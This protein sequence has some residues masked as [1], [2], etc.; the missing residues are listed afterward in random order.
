[1]TDPTTWQYMAVAELG[2]RPH[3]VVDGAARPG[4]VCTL[5]HWP[6]T[7]T[8][9][10]LWAD[11]SAEIV[12]R[13]LRRPRLLPADV[14]L[15]TVDHYDAD[16][17][18]ALA[19][20]VVEGLAERHGPLLAA[21][22]RAGDFGVVQSRHS[23]LVA[24]ALAALGSAER[25]LETLPGLAE[26]PQGFED[27]WGREAAAYD[28]A[29]AWRDSGAIDIEEDRARDLVIARID[30]DV[31]AKTAVGWAGSVVH[32]AALHSVTTCLRVA[33]VVGRR[34]QLHYRYESWVRL[35]ARRP[36]PR[37]DLTALATTLTEAEVDGGQ[38]R[39]DGAG[40]VTPRLARTD[41]GPSTLSPERWLAR[42]RT[43]LDTLDRLEAAW[44]PYAAPAD[45]TTAASTAG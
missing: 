29:C 35:A 37:V 42:V 12:L 44:D 4:T 28:A 11:T 20:L 25:A 24:F 6:R 21:A 22:A 33:E 5:S 2:D 16:G 36:R 19:L 26:R 30:E 27:L 45:A 13:A 32:P 41:G 40:A 39:F 43:A 31:V 8:P 7:P 23:A 18:I 1:V 3:V 17:M 14:R 10:R 34:Y 9:R 15:A 38:W